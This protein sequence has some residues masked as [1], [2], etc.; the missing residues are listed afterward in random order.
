[1]KT[2]NKY[3]VCQNG[4]KTNIQDV[5]YL[6]WK[7]IHQI[8]TTSLKIWTLPYLLNYPSPYEY[9]Y[10]YFKTTPPFCHEWQRGKYIK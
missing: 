8:L 9:D 1:M 4:H 3:N 6:K 7:K 2:K 10:S 5:I